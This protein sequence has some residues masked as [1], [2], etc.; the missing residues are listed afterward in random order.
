MKS[1][2]NSTSIC[3]PYPKCVISLS[4]DDNLMDVLKL[5]VQ[6]MSEHPSSMVPA[7]DRKHGVR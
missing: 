6:L 1:F 4:Q 7:F 3:R 2:S 5:L